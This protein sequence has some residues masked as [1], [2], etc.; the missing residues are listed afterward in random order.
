MSGVS[1]TAVSTSREELD[2]CHEGVQ[3]LVLQAERN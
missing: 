3:Q 1:T 2:E